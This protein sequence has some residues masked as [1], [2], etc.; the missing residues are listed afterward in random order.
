M[1]KVAI[2][3]GVSRGV[4]KTTAEH[5]A[6]SGYYVIAL[7]R[8]ISQVSFDSSSI[9]PYQI[10]ITKTEEIKMLKDHLKDEKIFVLINN[11]AASLDNF[12][13]LN[14]DKLNW[15]EAF[16]TNVIAVMELCKAFAGSIT[17]NKGHIVNITSI[18]A[19][20]PNKNS[21]HYLSSKSAESTLTEILRLETIGSG[22]KVTELIPGMINTHGDN[23]NAI[24]PKDISESIM[25]IISLPSYINID[26]LTVM[27]VNNGK[28]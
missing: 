13:V 7:S 25:W 10:D 5:L 9:E 19:Y 27:H 23:L 14:G 1:K 20:Y 3:T 21:G 16:S 2:V 6:N 12:E 17:E 28:Y 18:G 26:S 15:Q 11:A 4:G 24:E 8:D 22:L